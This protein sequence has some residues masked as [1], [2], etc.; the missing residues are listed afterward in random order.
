VRAAAEREFKRAYGLIW[1]L[2]QEIHR[3]MALS[4]V[5]IDQ[6]KVVLQG[7]P[8]KRRRLFVFSGYAYWRFLFWPQFAG[9]PLGLAV[10]C[11]SR[12]FATASRSFEEM[13]GVAAMNLAHLRPIRRILVTLAA[14]K[15]RIREE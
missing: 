6:Y 11:A 8:G 9:I 3:K 13:E 10:C 7:R 1:L 2:V 14:F 12:R 4:N 15:R 5:P